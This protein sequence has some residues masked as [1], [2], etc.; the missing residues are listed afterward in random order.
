MYFES[1]PENYTEPGEYETF[2]LATRLRSGPAS[3]SSMKTV[4]T[5]FL[6]L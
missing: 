5:P 6:K 1:E 3:K 4:R 2:A